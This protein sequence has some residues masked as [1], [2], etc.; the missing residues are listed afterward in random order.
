VSYLSCPK[1]GLTMFDR[2]PLTS[3]RDCPRC[4][5]RGTSVELERV[6]LAQGQ[7]AASVLREM[8]PK[9]VEGAE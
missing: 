4:S 6:S 5:R 1:C 7:A 3:P 8:Q 9:P 2:N